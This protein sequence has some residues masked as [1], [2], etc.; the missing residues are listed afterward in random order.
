MGQMNVHL[1]AWQQKQLHSP[2]ITARTLAVLQIKYHSGY[3]RPQSARRGESVSRSSKIRSICYSQST[4]VGSTSWYSRSQPCI[5][6][7]GSQTSS[8]TGCLAAQL[9][10]K[11]VTKRATRRAVK[12]ALRRKTGCTACKNSAGDQRPSRDRPC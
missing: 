7:V 12:L 3:I 6:I 2:R 5:F 4:F 8:Q 10:A 1:L 9:S 11:R